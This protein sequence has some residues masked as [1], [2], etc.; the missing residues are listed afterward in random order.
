MI[1]NPYLFCKIKLWTIYFC[2]PTWSDKCFWYKFSNIFT[3]LSKLSSRLYSNS[4]VDDFVKCESKNSSKNTSTLSSWT[5]THSYN[6]KS[7][8]IQTSSCFSTRPISSL[9]SALLRQRAQPNSSISGNLRYSPS[10]N[11]LSLRPSSDVETSFTIPSYPKSTHLIGDQESVSSLSAINCADLPYLTLEKNSRPPTSDLYIYTLRL[12]NEIF[13][14]PGQDLRNQFPPVNRKNSNLHCSTF[15]RNRD[16][17]K[18]ILISTELEVELIVNF[19]GLNPHPISNL[20]QVKHRTFPSLF[21]VT[22]LRFTS[23]NKPAYHQQW[24]STTFHNPIS[25]LKNKTTFWN[26][27]SYSL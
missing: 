21:V 20:F 3:V 13:N 5:A 14:H 22:S 11:P 7:R 18:L 8:S 19:N 24:G 6:L 2:K 12:D 4:F 1:N 25:C 27:C 10:K 17:T 15:T 9:I 23:T 26:P 16:L